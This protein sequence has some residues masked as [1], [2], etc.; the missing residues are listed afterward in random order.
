M[1]TVTVRELEDRVRELEK[2]LREIGVHARVDD[3][4]YE[5]LAP[6]LQQRL[7]AIVG[8]VDDSTYDND[9]DGDDD[10]DDDDYDDDEAG[11]ADDS[12]VATDED[13]DGASGGSE[14]LENEAATLDDA[15]AFKSSHPVGAVVCAVAFDTSPSASSA[16]ELWGGEWRSTT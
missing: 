6:H 12:S 10:Y 15:V 7:D 4:D 8:L 11:G 1:A 16:G 14:K 5:K 2:T 13:D 9:D 3:A